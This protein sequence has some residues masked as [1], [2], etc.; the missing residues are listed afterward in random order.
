MADY[1]TNF[2]LI[3][4]LPTEAAQQYAL[5]L[6]EAA[7]SAMMQDDPLLD[8]FPAALREVIEDWRFETDAN[9]PS[10]GWGLWLHS[11]DDGVDAVCAFVQHLLQKFNPQGPVTF[12]WSNDCSKP[13]VNAYGGGAALITAHKIKTMSTGQWVHRQVARLRLINHHTKTERKPHGRNLRSSSTTHPTSAPE[14][15]APLRRLGRRS[16]RR[17]A[18][19]YA[20]RHRNLDADPSS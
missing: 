18:C 19:T 3:V 13:R 1:F 15:A 6:A 17:S 5:A 20:S 16:K 8:D 7:G 14:P 4:P 12:E 10:N 2:S 9:E 11:Q